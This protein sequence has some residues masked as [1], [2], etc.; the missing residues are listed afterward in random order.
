M[1]KLD[2]RDDY[3]EE[4]QLE[5][6]IILSSGEGSKS[7]INNYKN[8]WV[9]VIKR[10]INDAALMTNNIP[11]W[12]LKLSNCKNEKK[13]RKIQI[14]IDKMKNIK[15][16]AISFL[17]NPDHKIPWGDFSIQIRCPKCKN[18]WVN[19]M[20]IAAEKSSK[21]PECKCIISSKY[22]QYRIVKEYKEKEISLEELLYLFEIN[23]I[24]EFRRK[25][26]QEIDFKSANPNMIKK[27]ER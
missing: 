3:T 13:I 10:A 27:E 22:I 4:E 2:I 11:K 12:E 24:D 19:F 15:E 23:N 7:T 26:K 18:E 20:S 25:A 16:T 5:R 9:K 21:C 8:L 6:E 14:E 1:N 17:F